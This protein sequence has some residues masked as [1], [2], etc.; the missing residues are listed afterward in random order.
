MQIAA[1][2]PGSSRTALRRVVAV[3]VGI[4]VAVGHLTGAGAA[5]A[6]VG[7]GT[8][9]SFAVLGGTTVTNT[10]PTVVSGDLGVSP[11]SAITGFPPGIVTNGTTHAADA[12]ALQAQ[13]DVTTAYNDAA[14]RASSA[15]ISADLGGQTLVGGVYTGATLGLTGALTLNGEGDADAVFIL[16]SAS[17]LITASA[18]TVVLINGAQACNVYWQIGSSATLGTDSTFT[19]TVLALTSISAMTGATVQGRLLARNG[20]VTLDTNTVVRPACATGPGTSTTTAAVPTSTSSST[21]TSSTICC[22]INTSSTSSTSTS[23]TAPAGGTTTTADVLGVATT[24][25]TTVGGAGGSSTSTSMSTTSSS[26]SGP[27]T[28][29]PAG[30]T[31]TLDRPTLPVTGASPVGPAALGLLAVAGG[32]AALVASRRRSTTR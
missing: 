31:T 1:R 8:A 17:T 32:S 21:S 18:S 11:G 16:R 2:T 10:G 3:S 27:T 29:T 6:P 24:T 4:A 19:G 26:V 15:T 14:G 25:S 28:S 30:D 5:E 23:T 7:L 9:S 22:P 20:A 12:V 13:A